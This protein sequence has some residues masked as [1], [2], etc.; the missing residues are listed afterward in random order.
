MSGSLSPATLRV[1][2]ECAAH[3]QPVEHVEDADGWWLRRTASASW[4]LASVLPHGGGRGELAWRVA[5]A[6]AAYRAW[7]T[8][9]SF[10]ISPG[11][12]PDGLDDLLDKRGYYE[13]APISLRVART[14]DVRAALG[15]GALEA[16][17]ERRLGDAWFGVWHAVQ[18]HGTPGPDRANL[19]RLRLP[20]AYASIIL[21]GKVVAVGRA[22]LDAGWAGLFGLATLPEARGRGA[23]RQVVRALADWAGVQGAQGMY[24]Q[25][26]A[27]NAA[28]NALYAKAGFTEAL[29]YHYRAL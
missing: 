22:V 18:G 7:R 27:G 21:G 24:L 11:V 1:L 14:A 25:V 12:C 6:E 20:S 29:R 5:R 15:P 16:R 28:A 9:L 4:W 8:P 19:E 13:D 23:G 2:Q 10:Q 17:V 26:E 3:A